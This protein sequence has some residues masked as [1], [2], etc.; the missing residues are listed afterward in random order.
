M[1]IIVGPTALEID[2]ACVVDPDQRTTLV[3]AD[4]GLESAS[5]WIARRP[6][7]PTVRG[8]LVCTMRA[9]VIFWVEFVVAYLVD[10]LGDPGKTRTC[11]PL[12]RRQ[13]L[14]PAEL[15]DLA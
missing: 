14:Y 1:T 10:F 5:T 3:S 9:R 11:D 12:L 15:R 6:P 2:S 13:M 4:L 8:V 7:R